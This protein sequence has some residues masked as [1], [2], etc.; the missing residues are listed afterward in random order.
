MR[1]K[2]CMRFSFIAETYR[3]TLYWKVQSL[4]GVNATV[5]K[6]WVSRGESRTFS[7]GWERGAATVK[8]SKPSRRIHFLLE[9][10]W[11]KIGSTRHNTPLWISHGCPFKKW[12]LSGKQV[13]ARSRLTTTENKEQASHITLLLDVVHVYKVLRKQVPS[14][15]QWI[16]WNFLADPPF[17]C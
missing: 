10:C 1:V 15:A 9:K 5:L 14:T 6:M 12:I 4:S 11:V 17:V 7:K 13:L 3:S 8:V 16:F 2:P